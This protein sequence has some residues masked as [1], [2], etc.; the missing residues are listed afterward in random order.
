M[1][2][3]ASFAMIALLAIAAW[4]ITVLITELDK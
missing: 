2:P 3:L 1:T 4:A